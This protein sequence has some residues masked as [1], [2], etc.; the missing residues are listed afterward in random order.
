MIIATMCLCVSTLAAS[1]RTRSLSNAASDSE[2]KEETKQE[3]AQ[4]A[5][6]IASKLPIRWDDSDSCDSRAYLVSAALAVD[7]V[8]SSNIQLLPPPGTSL[9]PKVLEQRE[10]RFGWKMH[11][12]VLVDNLVIDPALATAPLA[13]ETWKTEAGLSRSSKD[14]KLHIIPGSWGFSDP[15]VLRGKV[16]PALE[17][18]RIPERPKRVKDMPLFEFD[19]IEDALIKLQ[20]RTFLDSDKHKLCEHVAQ[21]ADGLLEKNLLAISTRLNVIYG[22][23]V[24]CTIEPDG[25]HVTVK[26]LA[27]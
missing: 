13:I 19:S 10:S 23:A 2:T 18:G 20:Q 11:V 12:A 25:Q 3:R 5:F 6:S 1:C 8:P 9:K 26:Q 22:P 24:P 15:R 7:D 17:S 27:R 16:Y 14:F 4:A 21:I